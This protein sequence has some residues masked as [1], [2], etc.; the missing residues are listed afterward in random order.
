MAKRPPSLGRSQVV[1]QQR[2]A[3]KVQADSRRGSAASRGYDADWRRLRLQYLAAHPLCL[4][5]ADADRVEAA[6]VVDH[7]VPIADRP[8]LRLDWSNLRPL[9][10]P[11]H[12]R[13][14]AREQAFGGKASRWP[15][16]LRPS[17]VP[18]H[19][20]CGPPASGKT[21]HVR[22]HA[23]PDDLVLDLDEIAAS[24]SGLGHHAWTSQWLEPALRERNELLGRL[25]RTPTSWPA[26]WL[27]VSEPSAAKRQWWWDTLKPKTITVLETHPDVCRS[28]IRLDPERADVIETMGGAVLRWWASY[29]RRPGETQIIT[30]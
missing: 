15:A 30:R 17:A 21:H 16:W 10:K 7:I 9:C 13:H 24:M 14:T 22:T 5:C 27:I 8:D 18:L 6:T 4:F 20:V 1:V 3:A 29:R 19:I 12:D 28:R 23:A 25:S 2:R 11:C 26:A